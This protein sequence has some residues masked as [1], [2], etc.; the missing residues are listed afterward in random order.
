[1]WLNAFGIYIGRFLRYNS[2]DIVTQP[3]SLFSEMIGMLASPVENRME[4]TMI[5]GYALFMTLLYLSI[6]KLS[7]S[8][9]SMNQ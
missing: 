2:W 8:F 6:R 1:M 9:H 5:F 3:L 7:E 4:W